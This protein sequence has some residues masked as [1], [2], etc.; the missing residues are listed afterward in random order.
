M[1]YQ[2]FLYEVDDGVATVRLNDPDRLNALTF[3]TYEELEKLTRELASEAQVK[4]LLLTGSGK[5]FCSGGSVHEII[6]RLLEMNADELYRF[7]RMTCDVV[8][9][10]RN[11]KKPIVAAVNGIA[12]GAGA[13]LALASDLRVV[14]ERAKF[15]FLFVKVG[16]SGADMGALYLLPRIV[17]QGKAAELLFLGDPVDAQEAYRIGLANRVVPHEKLM[18]E[19]CSLARRLRDG[20]LYAIGVTK[21]LLNT[22]ADMGLEAALEAEATAQ[23][24]CMQRDDFR[25]GHG[26]FVEKRAPQ[27]NRS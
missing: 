17:G 15:A 10:M 20:P 3:Q 19:A 13:M 14:S 5:G 1:S 21:E 25:E 2:S 6:G 26:A 18:E 16:L 11:L 8:K 4:V 27:F 12:A 24:G 7:T 23:A 9:N 22:E